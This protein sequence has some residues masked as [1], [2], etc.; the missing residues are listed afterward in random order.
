MGYAVK[1]V[2][3]YDKLV[4]V[5]KKAYAGNGLWG[6]IT[7]NSMTGWIS[8]DY[9]ER[10]TTFPELVNTSRIN[11]SVISVEE[12]VSITGSAKGGSESFDYCYSYRKEPD[13]SWIDIKGYSGSKSAAFSSDEPGTYTIRIKVH[14]QFTG[15]VVQKGIKLTVVKGFA[16]L[17]TISSESIK[18]GNKITIN[19]MAYGG[20]GS[21]E[22]SYSYKAIN[23]IN[24]INIKDY[25]DARYVSFTPKR[26]G[27]YVIRV[28]VHDNNY[29][30]VSQKGINLSVSNNFDNSSYTS[31][32]DMSY[33]ES[34]DIYAVADGGTEPYEYTYYCR[35][36]DSTSWYK[37][38]GYSEND[39]ITYKPKHSGK[40][41]FLVK[42][43]D[44][45]G[46][47]SKKAINVNVVDNRLVNNSFAESYEI[48]YG[49]KLRLTGSASCGTGDYMFAY[50]CRPAG[51]E[52]WTTIKGYSY[53]ENVEYIPRKTGEYEVVIR[54]RDSS[55]KV[56]K[57]RFTVNVNLSE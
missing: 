49:D 37:I 1:C 26:A 9:A 53:N 14:D 28:K 6:Y 2:V 31:V 4:T 7:Y 13:G 52:K 23:D 24:W 48:E 50:Y 40:Y 10:V 30:M 46:K 19:G 12:A 32:S 39:S 43:K 8:L 5:T 47:I 15:Q 33:G 20:S 51:A 55:G 36:D 16:N 35:R 44:A 21:Y 56:V 27:E 42:I 57:K 3:P 25:S 22:Y 41:E 18:L 38:S 11:K 45:D 54:A 34:L 29:K 17:S